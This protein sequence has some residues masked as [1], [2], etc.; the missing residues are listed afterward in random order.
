MEEPANKKYRR[1]EDLENKWKNED[2]AKAVGKM[3]M[4]I[5]NLKSSPTRS[6]ALEKKKIHGSGEY[7]N[8][9]FTPRDKKE[10]RGFNKRFNSKTG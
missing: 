2:T 8:I 9:S 3:K 1:Y 4:A 10:E 6:K 7:K 5:H